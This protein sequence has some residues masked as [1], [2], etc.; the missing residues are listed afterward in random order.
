MY[1]HGWANIKLLDNLELENFKDK[2]KEVIALLATLW[3]L[4]IIRIAW[5]I[6]VLSLWCSIHALL[7]V[8]PILLFAIQIMTKHDKKEGRQPPPCTPIMTDDE[9]PKVRFLFVHSLLGWCHGD[10]HVPCDVRPL[11]S[12]FLSSVLICWLLPDVIPTCLSYWWL[13]NGLH[14]KYIVLHRLIL[15]VADNRTYS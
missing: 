13:A 2:I 15:L 11:C 6:S 10:M 8:P 7:D 5:V 9:T 4:C 3:G 14:C 12:C 1:T